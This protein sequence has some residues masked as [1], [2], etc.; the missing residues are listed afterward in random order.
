MEED[1]I[2][3]F[4]QRIKAKYPDYQDID[5]VDLVEKV[6]RKHPAYA[7]KVK[8]PKEFSLLQATSGYPKID[9]LYEQMGRE[10]NV[11]PN[12]LLEQGRKETAFK[13]ENFY[14][15]NKS[16]AGAVGAGQFMAG[17]APAYGVTD[18]NN[19]V[20][21]IRGQAKY[22]RKLLD[23]FDNDEGLALAGYNSGEY[24]KSLANGKI[25]SIPET[26]DYVKV[27]Q[28]NLSNVRSKT[29]KPLRDYLDDKGGQPV[30]PTVQGQQTV[31]PVPEMADTIDAQI[32]SISTPGSKRYGVLPTDETQAGMLANSNLKP[33]NYQGKPIWIDEAKAKKGLKLKDKDHLQTYLDKNPAAL[34]TILGTPNAQ[35]VGDATGDSQPVVTTTLMKNGAPVEATSTV[36]TD[37]AQ[38][39]GVVD[40]H[41]NQ[42]PQG[43]TDLTNTDEVAA[44]RLTSQGMAEEVIPQ[45]Q[46]AYDVPATQRM[47]APLEDSEY[48]NFQKTTP[49][50]P[51][52]VK[53]A[54]QAPP[55]NNTFTE[56]DYK[57][58]LGETKLEDSPE[59]RQQFQQA[60]A[61]A[62][63]GKT[64][65]ESYGILPGEYENGKPTKGGGVIAQAKRE[66][67]K[68]SDNLNG[69]AYVYT[70]KD[71]MSD[72]DA[73]RDSLRS[74]GASENDI[75]DRVKA[76]KTSGRPFFHQKY[77]Q[78][79]TIG[80]SYQDLKDAG[81]K[82]VDADLRMQQVQDRTNAPD[83]R[84]L[85]YDFAS[86]SAK[87]INDIGKKALNLVNPLSTLL[88]EDV[89]RSAGGALG[90]LAATPAEIG[91]I[92][93]GLAQ[94]FAE[95]NPVLNSAGEILSNGGA[96]KV[97]IR[98]ATADNLKAFAGELRDAYDNAESMLSKTGDTTSKTSQVTTT[99]FK[100][101]GAIPKIAIVS[102]LPGGMIGGF[103]VEGLAIAK[104]RGAS[105]GDIIK[106]GIKS[107]V[108]AGIFKFFPEIIGNQLGEVSNVV[109]SGIEIPAIG[110]GSYTVGKVA[111]DPDEDNLIN[112][113][114][115]A[116]FHGY[117]KL[118][119]GKVARVRDTKGN[120]VYLKNEGDKI[121]TVEPQKA[122]IEM[123][124]PKEPLGKEFASK[125]TEVK[126]ESNTNDKQRT[127]SGVLAT[128][129][130]NDAG[131][132]SEVVGIQ[133]QRPE[134]IAE[135]TADVKNTETVEKP[136]VVSPPQS[137]LTAEQ[138]EES[139]PTVKPKSETP[140]PIT[141]E[142]GKAAG[143]TAVE[144]P[145]PPVDAQELNAKKAGEAGKK[146]GETV[147]ESVNRLR[148][149]AKANKF[150][151]K[152]WH[153]ERPGG[154]D[155]S[156]LNTFP[157]HGTDKFIPEAIA[158]RANE[159]YQRLSPGVQDFDRIKE[160]GGFGAGELTAM[161]P[162]WRADAAK[163]QSAETTARS[164]DAPSLLDRTQAMTDGTEILEPHTILKKADEVIKQDNVEQNTSSR[165]IEQGV[166]AQGEGG[167][168]GTSNADNELKPE[169]TGTGQE[170]KGK[171]EAAPVQDEQ[172]LAP[173]AKNKIVTAD[174]VAEIR[175]AIAEKTKGVMASGIDPELLKLYTELGAAHVEAGARKFADFAKRMTSEGIDLADDQMRKLYARIRGEHGFEGME[176]VTEPK[177]E[178]TSIMHAEI[179]A[180]RANRGWDKLSKRIKQG[181]PELHKEVQEIIAKDPDA[182]LKT[183]E[184][185]KEH[186]KS[187]P[188]AAEGVLLNAHLIDM[189]NESTNVA[190]RYVE[191]MDSDDPLAM[192][193]AEMDRK[194]S[195]RKLQEA[196]E[197]A[198]KG[199]SE[200][201]AALQSQKMFADE[202]FEYTTL[203]RNFKIAKGREPSSEEVRQLQEIADEH[204]A[205]SEALE[206]ELAG[207]GKELSDIKASIPPKHILDIAENYVNKL[208]TLAD[209]ERERLRAKGN[210]FQAGIDPRD[211]KSAAIIG[212][213]HLANMSLDFAKWSDKMIDEFGEKVKPHLKKLFEDA[214]NI[215]K[216]GHAALKS[217]ADV[218]ARTL[219]AQKTWME[220]RIKELN[221]AITKRERITRTKTTLV[222]DAE[223]EKLQS[224][225]KSLKEDYDAIFP[226]ERTI[227]DERRLK[228]LQKQAENRIEQLD[229]AIKNNERIK[230]DKPSPI[231]DK[232]LDQLREQRAEL[233]KKYDEQ[234]PK[235]TSPRPPMTDA[236]R[237]QA[238]EK[239]LGKKQKA[240][241]EKVANKDFSETEKREPLDPFAIK[242]DKNATA[243]DRARA[244][245]I[246]AAQ[247]EVGKIEKRFRR[248]KDTA[249]RQ[250]ELKRKWIQRKLKNFVR[251]SMLSAVTVIEKLGA[252]SIGRTVTRPVKTGIG[253][254][255]SKILPNIASKA[256]IEGSKG[257][258]NDVKNEVHAIAKAY[259]TGIMDM[260]RT[261][262]G[263]GTDI[264]NA[265]G[266]NE[267]YLKSGKVLPFEMSQLI[268]QMHDSLKAP[269]FRSEYEGVLGNLILD[270]KK[271][272]YPIDNETLFVL[273]Q[274]AYQYAQRAKFNESRKMT[275]LIQ[276]HVLG[277]LDNNEITPVQAIGTFLHIVMP[278]HKISTNVV[279]QSLESSPLGLVKGLGKAA[280]AKIKGLDNLTPDQADIIMRNIKHGTF[281]SAMYALGLF[282]GGK[283]IGSFYQKY[284]KDDDKDKAK[285]NTV[286]I[287]G[288]RI[289]AA[290]LHLPEFNAMF[291]GATTKRIYEESLAAKHKDGTK[292]GE[293]EAAARAATGGVR[294]LIEETPGLEA[295]DA[296]TNIYHAIMGG[297]EE[298]MRESRYGVGNFIAGR[299][300]PGFMRNTAEWFDQDPAG[301]YNTPFTKEPRGRKVDTKTFGESIKTQFQKSVPFWRNKLPDNTPK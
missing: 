226:P 175:K 93:G 243:E 252:A 31:K 290:L 158:R 190:K 287:D 61:V 187:V 132:G 198:W 19:P 264:S 15:T 223:L 209:K 221:N 239:R 265:Y 126:N 224:Q 65:V 220:N 104:L 4:A 66:V 155:K 6:V 21:S 87:D 103:T 156:E 25:P 55:V 195:D 131:T 22:M 286:Q 14:G 203:E 255:A 140:E 143:L 234:F 122:E 178:P 153:D 197:V 245:R 45:D 112:S 162:D 95:S 77:E 88:P 49:K 254:V 53:K 82:D 28:S 145:Q 246:V 10:E 193:N 170:T 148:D 130:Q 124:M 142:Q 24:R 96:K 201:G 98:D 127:E 105:T 173:F 139:K 247:A 37:P 222:P 75:N 86:E 26:Q 100:M 166:A 179:N 152:T 146:V 136:S 206:A 277:P 72:E 244:T 253:Y 288:V 118:S 281:G 137:K 207:Q 81:I 20:Q 110:L 215:L 76:I 164:I 229:T 18:R 48:G 91:G 11:D 36:V 9:A 57:A 180:D 296:L 135:N 161:Y 144:K 177:G 205:K 167:E 218:M 271:N 231:A 233:Q 188:N 191:A 70:P 275:D 106:S 115:I 211:L 5:D 171:P 46:Q 208:K 113:G 227:S 80:I 232:R 43:Q 278:I 89:Q 251:G 125:K 199:G 99:L 64:D 16:S 32:T 268:G 68:Q 34:M 293:K 138:V 111:G 83:L 62:P 56:D 154:F 219:K 182:P 235:E 282:A 54:T 94:A 280:S 40:D 174:R 176:D 101:A 7:S 52:V 225:A 13:P 210:V 238:L 134:Q 59:S 58:W 184:K 114:A 192:A 121:V 102:S 90:Q 240:I 183:F 263:R 276:K 299:A 27:I 242:Q 217:D 23:Q 241:S 44:K 157:L 78:G 41:K 214:Q 107:G 292:T 258:V 172:E 169:Q 117:G 256:A 196:Q 194:V 151:D 250:N 163:L 85:A 202:D 39:K 297:D 181:N 73:Y 50:R 185:F 284:D 35:D 2:P 230:R 260:G 60:L 128:G 12:L 274:K 272:R 294:G 33:Y 301:H 236:Q 67:G 249:E 248:M 109:K 74:I 213:D 189:K 259:T 150:G 160:R 69:L 71:G 1:D 200:R 159:V 42:F 270:A 149:I 3:T 119:E 279:A 47:G 84:P 291:M 300:A 147:D 204:K 17:T 285:Y 261:L 269:A 257:F 216:G 129:K 120:E 168:S 30:T 116:L 63:Q 123:V 237:L 97:Q 79:V 262:T 29:G 186:P 289:P 228:M 92:V 38:V 295:A 267:N 51:V 133:A 273:G 266:Q 141:A 8:L 283:V 298:Q 165:N 212:A 108:Q